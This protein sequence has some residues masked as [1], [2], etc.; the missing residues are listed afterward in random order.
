MKKHITFCQMTLN[1][2]SKTSES[3]RRVQP[4]VDRIVIV[5]GG[6]VDE[7]IATLRSW[8]GVDLYIHPWDDHFSRQR[9]NCLSHCNNTDW[10]L[11]MDPDEWLT[12]DS[13][14]NL[15]NILNTNGFFDLVRFKCRDVDMYGY[16]VGRDAPV[17]FYKPIL[18]K[19][20]PT[21][22]YKGNLHE[23]I[24]I[25]GRDAYELQVEYE[26][27][28]VKQELSKSVSGTRNLFIGGT[29]VEVINRGDLWKKSWI[30]FRRLV[31]EVTGIERWNDFNQYLLR[32]NIDQSIKHIIIKNRNETGY[33]G[34]QEWM[35]LYWTYFHLYHPEEEPEDVKTALM[36][37]P[38]V[39][40]RL[41]LERKNKC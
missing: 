10:I 20:Y 36:K 12:E 41:D 23:T 8:G 34:S 1:N 38:S 35:E 32:G 24:K 4:Y 33:D 16:K 40:Y 30:P 28:H 18:F 6:S 27:Y 3:I 7:T 13:A 22:S 14:K 2:L 29:G 11:F 5:D 19:Y 37:D 21:N 9:N 39:I 31:K 25:D 26:Y 17:N 15:Q